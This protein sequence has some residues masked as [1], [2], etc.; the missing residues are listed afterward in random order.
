MKLVR[1]Y[2]WELLLVALILGAATINTNISPYYADP[3]QIVSGLRYMAIPGIMALVLAPIVIQGEIDISLVSLFAVGTVM[4]GWFSTLGMPIPLAVIIVVLAGA[5]AGCVNGSIVTSY[6]LPSMAITLGSMAAFQGIAFLLPGGNDGYSSTQFGDAYKWLGSRQTSI[7]GFPVSLIVLLIVAVLVALLMHQT[8]YGRMAFAAGTNKQAARYSGARVN[9]T[10]I[11]AYVMA[12]AMTMIASLIFV[13][14]SESARGDVGGS[15]L[16]LVVTCVA[17]GGVDLNG[18]R[19][20]IG[21]VLLSVVLLGTLYNGM[22]LANVDAPLQVVVFGVLL[23][24][25]VLTPRL[26]WQVQRLLRRRRAS[27]EGS[28]RASQA[29]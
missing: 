25:S 29:S 18:G 4:L 13:G 6:G 23:I 8:V 21:G 16:L 9:R 24:G 17:L 12:G 20:T 26:A 19:G 5:V 10:L 7:G 27:T 2:S 1:A 3:A 22:G 28:Q 11:A 14:Y 15:Q